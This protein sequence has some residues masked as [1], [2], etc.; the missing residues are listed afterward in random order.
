MSFTHFIHCASCS[1]AENF[2]LK[3]YLTSLTDFVGNHF[4]DLSNDL[5]NSFYNLNQED[6][7]LMLNDYVCLSD[8]KLLVEFDS[9]EKNGDVTVWNWLRDQIREDVMTTFTMSIDY[10]TY[11]TR[12]GMDCSTAYLL[13]DGRFVDSDEIVDIL[14]Q[15][16]KM[17]S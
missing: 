7:I 17:S 10:T 14:E 5:Q 13:K 4:E 3:E 15:Y 6:L 1:V 8:G 2:D 12:N 16:I 11:D 9:E